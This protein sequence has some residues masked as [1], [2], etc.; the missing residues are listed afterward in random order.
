M[1]QRQGGKSKDKVSD[2]WVNQT[3]ITIP[4]LV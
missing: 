1:N 4:F 2:L 3:H